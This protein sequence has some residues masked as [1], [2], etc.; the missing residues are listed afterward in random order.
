MELI[1]RIP[2]ER[3]QFLEKMTYETFKQHTEQCKTE[4]DRKEYYDSFKSYCRGAIKTKGITKRIY[5]YSE[6]IKEF[7]G[8]RLFSGGSI[9]GL[10]S[11]FRGFLVRDITTDIDVKNCHPMIL[12]HLCKKNNID[13]PNLSYY[14]LNRSDILARLGDGAKELILKAVN[15]DKINRKNTDSFIKDL[16]KEC[17]KIQVEICCLEK[18]EYI[19]KHKPA[20]KTYN[21]LGSAINRVLCVVENDILQV[22]IK[23]LTIKNIEIMTLMFDGCLIY[24]DHYNNEI[25]LRELEKAILDHLSIPLTLTYKEH[26]QSIECDAEDFYTLN[27]QLEEK[28]ICELYNTFKLKY[29]TEYGLAFIQSQVSYSFMIGETMQIFKQEQMKQILSPEFYLDGKL[30]RPWFDRWCHDKTRKTYI[31]VGI[32]PHDVDV[33]KDYL[34]LWSGFA[35][36]KLDTEIEDVTPILNHIKIMMNHHDPS[37]EFFLNWLSNLFQYPSSTS[38]FVSISSK[39]GSGKSA[40]ID[41][42]TYM[43]GG[44]KSKEISDMSSELFGS[45]NAELRDVVLMN[46]NEVERHDAG[47][48]YERLK[49][50]ITSPK[51]RIHPKGQSPYDVANLRKFISTNNNPHAIVIKEGNRRY[52]AT[53]SS[54]ELIG[55]MEY[56][57]IFYELIKSKAIQYSFWK[58]LMDR[59]VKK[60]LTARDIPETELMREAYV[61]NR[62]PME[63]FIEELQVGEKLYI[64]DVYTHYKQWMTSKGMEYK[65]NFKQFSMKFNRSI[66]PHIEDKGRSDKLIEG[67][68]D[69]RR[70]IILK[71]A[72]AL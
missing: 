43:V 60:Q 7:S 45:F 21:Y 71:Q 44:D 8:G 27:E 50:Q 6:K 23:N 52:F 36:E 40:L 12:E 48:C 56:F 4:K 1:E 70:F 25:L 46:M 11:S 15:S 20:T 28:T 32:Y 33:P 34:N 24:G 19:T 5:A 72:G 58:F 38:I 49:T 41:L 18:Y 16:D 9:Q 66:E 69:R 63:D 62:D 67:V 65:M 30:L 51:V 57:D 3:I 61:L 59:P 10:K 35:V 31:D 68:R 55:N 37:Y 29:E 2:L 22:I 53:E 14:N 13:C 64:D 54:N 47:K 39:E 17:K 42:I 26:S